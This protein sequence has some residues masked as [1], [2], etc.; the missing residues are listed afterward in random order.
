MQKYGFFYTHHG[1]FN[2]FISYLVAF[3]AI[4]RQKKSKGK[5]QKIPV[6]TVL[7]FL[8]PHDF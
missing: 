8:L 2:E 3:P 6:K 4:F 7:Q 5:F 1:L